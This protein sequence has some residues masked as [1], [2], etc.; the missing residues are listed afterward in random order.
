MTIQEATEIVTRAASQNAN[1]SG[2]AIR[3]LEAA[4]MVITYVR[5]QEDK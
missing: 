4:A 3:I 2:D 5:E 1:G